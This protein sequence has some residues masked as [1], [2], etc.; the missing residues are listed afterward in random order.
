MQI[1]RA[2]Q[3]KGKSQLTILKTKTTRVFQSEPKALSIISAQSVNT[4]FSPKE[5]RRK[6]SLKKG[7]MIQTPLY[8]KIT[9]MKCGFYTNTKD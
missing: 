7:Y 5:G 6:R 3:Y 9:T 2:Q 1:G 4:D 8:H